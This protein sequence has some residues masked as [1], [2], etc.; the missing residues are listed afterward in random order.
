MM[1]KQTSEFLT[2]RRQDIPNR[3]KSDIL[4]Y[5]RSKN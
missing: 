4:G 5:F 1:M 3:Q 2:L